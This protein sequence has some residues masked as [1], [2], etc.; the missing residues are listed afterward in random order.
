MKSPSVEHSSSW[1]TVTSRLMRFANDDPEN[2]SGSG[3][4]SPG[5]AVRRSNRSDSPPYASADHRQNSPFWQAGSGGGEAA[6]AAPALVSSPSTARTSNC[7]S[8]ERRRPEDM[9]DSPLE[10]RPGGRGE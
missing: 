2:P 5:F 6:C 3:M 4:H 7:G 9:V 1:Y 8:R 10:S